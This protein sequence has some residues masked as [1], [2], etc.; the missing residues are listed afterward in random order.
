MESFAEE[1]KGCIKIDG[2][3]IQHISPKL[4]RKNLSILP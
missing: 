1:P 3:D 4:L 2:I